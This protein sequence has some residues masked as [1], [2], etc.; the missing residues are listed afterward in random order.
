MDI[1]VA[2]DDCISAEL[3]ANSLQEFGYTVTIASNGREAYDWIRT[4]RFQ[5]VISDWEMPE[6]SGVELCREIRRRRSSGYVYVIMLT[7]YSGVENIVNGLAAGADDFL[8][9]PFQP[10]E[11]AVRL[12][13]GERILGLQSR[14]LTI[15]AL[16][17]LAESRDVETGA[18]LERIREYCRV[19]AE[20][21]SR[22]DAYRDQIDGEFVNLMYMTSPLHDI[23]KVGIPDAILL[24]PGRLTAEEFDVMK[25]HTLIGGQTLESLAAAQPDAEYLAMARDIALTHH[26]KFD[27]SGYPYGLAGDEIPLCGRITALADVYDALTTRRVYKPEYGHEVARELILEGRDCH[28][29]P[30]IVDSFLRCEAEFVAIHRRFADH[31]TEMLRSPPPAVLMATP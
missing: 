22:Q 15:F 21:L 31:A 14:D 26:E 17:K 27:G 25:R 9:K 28:F 30:D 3:L 11:L 8:T 18:H 12:R 24:K 19:L 13:V 20:D 23:G 29:D 5:L 1:L 2:D 4:G 16:A 7:S 10:A 6:M